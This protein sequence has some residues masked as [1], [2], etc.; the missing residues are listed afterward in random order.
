[1]R[2]TTFINDAAMLPNMFFLH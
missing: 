1:M 2:Q